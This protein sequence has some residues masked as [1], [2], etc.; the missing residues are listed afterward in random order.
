[1]NLQSLC[2]EASTLMEQQKEKLGKKHKWILLVYFFR[3]M[4]GNNNKK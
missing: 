2:L 4:D 1:M 3:V